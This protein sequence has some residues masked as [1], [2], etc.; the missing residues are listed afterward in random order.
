MKTMFHEDF[1]RGIQEF[2]KEM[3]ALVGCPS[4]SAMSAPGLSASGAKVD[5]PM[6]K[7]WLKITFIVNLVMGKGLF[8]IR[9]NFVGFLWIY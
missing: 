8:V 9:Y 4:C 1:E 6:L 7:S 2:W 3:A 5:L